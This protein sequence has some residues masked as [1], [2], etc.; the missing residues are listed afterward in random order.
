MILE[1]IVAMAD[2]DKVSVIVPV[3]NGQETVEKCIDSILAQ[4]YPNVEIIIINDGSS[5]KTE[6]T[7]KR[8]YSDN[9][10]V[11]LISQT[12]LGVSAARNR[13]LEH[14]NAKYVAFV[15]CDDYIEPFMIEKMVD[16]IRGNELSMCGYH[17]G[18][19]IVNGVC[20]NCDTR[21]ALDYIVANGVY[22]GF[23]WNKLFML[24]RIKNNKIKFDSSIHMCEDLIFCIEY[25]QV[26]STVAMIPDPLYHYVDNETNMSNSALSEKRVSVL[27]A[28]D[29]MLTLPAVAGDDVIR[30]KMLNRMAAHC[31]NLYRKS[32][33]SDKKIK[34]RYFQTIGQHLNRKE[35]TL[36]K[37][38]D[39][40][41]K[42]KVMY[43]LL[44]LRFSSKLYR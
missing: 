32:I 10:K 7:V 36:L 23:L 1:R 40:G 8:L 43:V 24:D 33:R 42:T 3:Y 27:A 29:K 30:R 14:S 13:G 17:W 5:D 44:K 21:M 19:R 11:H 34:D 31:I 18:N 9:D 25:I 16:A 2:I 37:D 41:A 22:K 15:D 26:I 6:E 38:S 39:Y 35:I 20:I 12:N 4:T 28:Y